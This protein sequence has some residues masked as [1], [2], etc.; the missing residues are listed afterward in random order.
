MHSYEDYNCVSIWIEE[1][2]FN[3]LEI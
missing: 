2:S 1:Q 3:F